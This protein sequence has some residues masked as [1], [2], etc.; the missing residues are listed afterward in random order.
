MV[1]RRCW[2]S[3]NTAAGVAGE[4]KEKAGISE[5]VDA[6][7]VMELVAADVTASDISERSWNLFAVKT[8]GCR[9]VGRTLWSSWKE[10]VASDVGRIG[11]CKALSAGGAVA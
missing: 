4:A 3:A 7:E 8:G 9:A 2:W 5:G 1:R 10:E 11:G 6:V